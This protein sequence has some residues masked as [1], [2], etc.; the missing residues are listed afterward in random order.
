[1][2]ATKDKSKDEGNIEQVPRLLNMDIRKRKWRKDKDEYD[3]ESEDVLEIIVA[4]I[5]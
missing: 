3:E 4:S 2:K 5:L 1:M